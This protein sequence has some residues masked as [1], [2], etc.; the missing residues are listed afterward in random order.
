MTKKKKISEKKK[1]T[2]KTILVVLVAAIIIGSPLIYNAINTA[3]IKNQTIAQSDKPAADQLMAMAVDAE[4]KNVIQSRALFETAMRQY[5]Y[6]VDTSTDQALQD[7]A[8]NGIQNCK[9][10]IWM[11]DHGDIK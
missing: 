3:N 9:S 11:I 8:Q 2:Y 4:N 5:Q 7:A 10:Q 6:V 1:L